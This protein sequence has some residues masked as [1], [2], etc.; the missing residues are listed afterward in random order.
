MGNPI[1][2][3]YKKRMVEIWKERAIFQAT[4]HRLP[5][6]VGTIIMNGRFSDLDILEK[7]EKINRESR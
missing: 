5:G 4:S 7:L 2:R 3:D 1:K 6:H